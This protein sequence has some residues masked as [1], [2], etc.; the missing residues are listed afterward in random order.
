VP[1]VKITAVASDGRTVEVF[2]A[3]GS[4][5]FT[6]LM[7]E[8]SFERLEGGSSR[9]TWKADNVEVTVE[10][11]VVRRAG[12]SSGG[13]DWQRGAQLPARV[14][15]GAAPATAAPAAPGTAPA[16]APAPAA[17][18]AATQQSGGSR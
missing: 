2:N 12:E 3:P 18:P 16:T 1:G 11:R 8:G 17:A 6:R 9:V 15:G 7:R 14:A 10:M 5:G 13:G 4:N